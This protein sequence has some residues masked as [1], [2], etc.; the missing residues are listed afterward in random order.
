MT[1]C[2]VSLCLARSSFV[3]RLSSFVFRPSSIGRRLSFVVFRSSCFVRRPSSF[4]NRPLRLSF[5]V[6]RLS[7]VVFRSSCFVLRLSSFV[8]RPSSQRYCDIVLR[9]SLLSLQPS[10]CVPCSL[11]VM[12]L[13]D[14]TAS[15][16]AGCLDLGQSD[17]QSATLTGK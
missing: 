5:V 14:R 17:G 6:R 11:F 1:R 7:F 3:L 16:L 13:R 9:P 12:L 15:L 8:L 4:V 10:A 2:A